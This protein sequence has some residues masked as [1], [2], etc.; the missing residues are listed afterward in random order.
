M[1]RRTASSE[2]SWRGNTSNVRRMRRLSA[3]TLPSTR[4]RPTRG[5]GAATSGA[6][7]ES[8]GAAAPRESTG[9]WAPGA[10]GA[11]AAAVRRSARPS[12][13]NH[14]PARSAS[15]RSPASE[16]ARSGARSSGLRSSGRRNHRARGNRL[17]VELVV[18]ATHTDGGAGWQLST[19]DEFGEGVLEQPLDRALERAG[20]ERRVEAAFHQQ[21]GGLGGDVEV[22]FLGTQSLLDQPQQDSHDRPHV[23]AR[24][25]VEH[26]HVV[27]AIQEFRVERALQLF[28]DRALDFL[29]LRGR[30]IRLLEPEVTPTRGDLPPAQIRRHDDD[31]VLEIHPPARAV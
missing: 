12:P 29:E 25:R 28:V 5:A 4:T 2:Y 3:V 26:D 23:L 22:D 17:E 30:T 27:D 20:P 16:A 13:A 1:P 10:S 9:T 19:Q 14:A 7:D 18:L 15:T 24:E 8:T 21:L 6:A 31:R 11:S